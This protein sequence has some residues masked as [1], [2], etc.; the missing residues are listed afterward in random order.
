MNEVF[1]LL[2]SNLGDRLNYLT[3]ASNIIELRIGKIFRKS[4][5][6][7]TE[8]FGNENQPFFLNLVISVLSNQSPVDLLDITMNIEQSMGRQRK[9]KWEERNIDI[10]ILFYGD[11][12]INEPQLIIPHPGIEFRRFTLA[13]LNEIIPFFVL[14][15]IEIQLVELLKKSKDTLKVSIFRDN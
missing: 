12:K 3:T 7:E 6:Y 4:S 10:D 13:P 1:F 5:I 8:P 11:K 2:G 15:N 9:E 14:P